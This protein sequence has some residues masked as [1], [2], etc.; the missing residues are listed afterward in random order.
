[1]DQSK[2]IE[3]IAQLSNAYGAP[4]FED[5]VLTV[6]QRWACDF[7]E[8]TSDAMRNL[9]IRR[10]GNTGKRPMVLLDAHSDEVAFMVHSVR[11]NGTI[12][13]I[14]LGGWVDYTLPAHTVRIRN[15]AGQ[16]IP[17]MIASKPIHYMTDEEYLQPVRQANMSIDVGACSREEAISVFGIAP[18]QPIVPD[19]AFTYDAKN[20]LMWGK[21]FD[22]RLGCAALLGTLAALDGETLSVDITAGMAT[23]EELDMRGAV[24]TARVVKPDV[25]IVF[26]GCPADDTCVPEAE[27]QTRIKHG[28]MLRH[29]DGEML[30]NPRFM[31]FALD[32]ARREGIPAQDGVRERSATN[33]ASIHLSNEGVPTIVIGL[34]IR[35]IHTHVGIAAYQ[36]YKHAVQLAAAIL[37]ALDADTILSF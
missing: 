12:K 24:I 37:R 34:P 6:A 26:E 35:Y 13:F 16:W 14:P 22:C 1:M 2:A 23:Q 25:A 32:T 27:M 20:D 29:I 17:G 31:R 18:G 3:M 5:D 11:K 7:G 9:Y 10:N 21:A 15:N 19:T 8:I 4:G 28:P 33:G 30:T 36:D